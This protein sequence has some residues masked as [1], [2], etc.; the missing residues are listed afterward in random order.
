MSV[1]SDD[2]SE[3]LVTIGV[4]RAALQQRGEMRGP[5]S[6]TKRAKGTP[7]NRINPYNKKTYITFNFHL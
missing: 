2:A 3:T 4:P 7:N 1:Q 6:V 5:L